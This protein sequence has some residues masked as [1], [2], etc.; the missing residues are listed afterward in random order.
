[1]V[2]IAILLT[3]GATAHFWSGM[4]M[5]AIL[6][7]LICTKMAVQTTTWHGTNRQGARRL[8]PRPATGSIVCII[9]LFGTHEIDTLHGR[10]T[11]RPAFE[12]YASLCR[13]YSPEKAQQITGVPAEQI[14]LVAE[15]L[16][17]HRPVSYYAWSGVG[18]IP[19]R[20]KLAARCAF[21]MPS[22]A[23]SMRQVA[24]SISR[25]QD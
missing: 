11:C 13:T 18:Q 25:G 4:T 23:T 12:L 15:M 20:R 5:G 8:R 6:S 22:Q 24:M 21:C 19:M 16:H 17:E 10:I 7:N 14:R 2:L 9:S 3:A 1:M